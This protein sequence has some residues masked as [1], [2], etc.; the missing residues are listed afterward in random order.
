M[1]IDVVPPFAGRHSET[2]TAGTLLRHAGVELSEPMLFGLGEGLSF[3]YWDSPALEAPFLGGR[4][5]PHVLTEKLADALG[6]TLD[7]RETSSPIAAWANV[8]ESLDA[9]TPVGLRLD[10]FHLDY[11]AGRYHNGAHYVAMTGYDDTRAFLVDTADHGTRVHTTLT[12]LEHARTATGP[13]TSHNLSYTLGPCGETDRTEAVLEA[14]ESTA[15]AF[16]HPPM[17]NL[18]HP[19]MEK[20]ANHLPT[21]LERGPTSHLTQTAAQ[22]EHETALFRSMYADF[23]AEAARLTGDPAVEAGHQA[24]AAVTPKWQELADLLRQAGE[25]GRQR[26]LDAAAGLL[27]ELASRERLAMESLAET[28][29]RRT[30]V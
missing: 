2:T 4:V 20:A 10:S 24:Y 21:W 25:T 12:S 7:T 9:G 19:G 18:G 16:L 17:Q 5:K 22:V 29:S 26:P 28:T 3:V 6:F 30:A 27:H 1:L 14:I 8:R 15:D 13:M 23:L 11:F